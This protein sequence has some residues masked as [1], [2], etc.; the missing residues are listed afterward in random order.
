MQHDFENKIYGTLYGKMVTQK[1]I[2]FVNYPESKIPGIQ[3]HY[4]KLKIPN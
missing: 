2:P 1:E 3:K 4:P